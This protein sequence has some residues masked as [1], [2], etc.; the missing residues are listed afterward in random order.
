M[1][2]DG[3]R[4]RSW[5]ARLVA[6]PRRLRRAGRGGTLAVS[7]VV[8]VS[9]SLDGAGASLVVALS[10]VLLPLIALALGFGD[11]FFVG[12]GV[13]RRRVLL[14][15]A[16]GALAALVACGVLASITTASQNTGSRVLQ[17][18][19]HAMLYGAVAT[20]AGAW[21]ALLVGRGSDYLARK[22]DERVHEEW[23]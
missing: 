7:L 12:H 1:F 15:A 6:N 11:G 13:G 4:E 19:L 18:V 17:G 20:A 2:E 16:G 5:L 23:P 22:I 8:G 3:E 9:Q 10:W 21:I 14:M